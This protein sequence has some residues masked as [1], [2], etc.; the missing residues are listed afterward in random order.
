MP[1]E[2]D[3][4][5]KKPNAPAEPKRGFK[6]RSTNDLQLLAM[7]LDE[8]PLLRERVLRFLEGQLGK[9]ALIKVDAEGR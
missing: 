6:V 7:I 3:P 5:G 8:D 1:R 4:K 9:R 2:I